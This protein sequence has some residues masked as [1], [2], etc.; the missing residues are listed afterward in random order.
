MHIKALLDRIRDDEKRNS[1]FLHLTANEAQMS[2]TARLF[3]G[4]KISERYYMGRGENDIKD[5]GIFTALSLDSVADIVDAA[6]E[7]ARE[8]LGAAVVNLNLLSGVHAMMCSLLAST[9]PGDT[10]M[11][12]PKEAGGHF[13]TPG[14]LDRVGRRRISATFDLDKLKFNAE[15]TAEDYHKNNA[16]AFYMDVSYYLNPHNLTEIRAALGEEAII[17]YDASHTMGLILGQQFQAPLK[18]G[19]N[20]ISA[21]TH[22]TL[23]GPQKGMVAFRDKVWGERVNDIIN[24]A[25]YSSPHTHHVIA[26][27]V[28]LLELKEFGEEYAQQVIKNSNAVGDAFVKRGYGV[29][30]GNTGRYSENHQTHIFIDDKGERLDLYKKLLDNNISTNFDIPLGDRLYIRFGSQEITRRGMK[31]QEMDTIADLI[32]RAFKG[33]NVKADVVELNRSFPSIHY[34]FDAQLGL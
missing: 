31:E 3:L 13:A 6:E 1:E 20:V 4:S 28:T 19:A 16:K 2:E 30:K 33:E 17:I 27:S 25:L 11:T 24:G 32:D 8:M 9:E 23:P 12:V 26:L 10:V 21:N 14:I 18:E 5:Y 15:K 22:K 7:A 34:S 29:R